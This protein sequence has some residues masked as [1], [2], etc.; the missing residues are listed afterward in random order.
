M[1][2]ALVGSGGKTTLLKKLAAQYL[3]E[4]KTVFVTTTTHMFI[5]ENTLLTE[6]AEEIIRTLQTT[7]YAM[8]GKTDGEKIIALSKETFDTVCAHADVVLVEADGS[9]QMPLKYPNDRE[10][11]IPEHTDEIIIVCGLQA[12]GRPAKEVC[13]RLALVREVLGIH[14]ETIITPVHIQKLLQEGY[15]S[16]LRNTYPDVKLTIAP[17]HNHSLY[18]R[19]IA[20]M[21]KNECDVSII[22]KE[23]FCP[24]PTLFI[25]G[26]GHVAKETA[27]LAKYLDFRVT[28]IDDR[29]ELANTKN[30]PTA[31]RIICDSYD[32][33]ADYLEPDSCYVVVTPNHKADLQCVSIILPTSYRYLGMIGSKNKVAATFENLRAAGFS[34]EQIASIF[35]PIGLSIG[36]VTPAEI[37]FSILAQIIQEKNKTHSASADRELLECKESG[38]L[39]IITEKH[40]STPRGA[41]SMMFVGHNKIL[42]SIGGGEP[43]RLVIN[44]ARETSA[45]T[46]RE[47]RLNNQL[48]KG[49]DMVCGGTITV[50]F[51][52]ME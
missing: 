40:G 13:H 12:L 32:N 2:K 49:L 43:E 41:G 11:V 45:V 6:D 3:A 48:H 20:A 25:C 18:Q 42:G 51:I 4:G 1:I 29:E 36:A 50:L 37:A 8:A 17:S 9:K 23:W 39:C 27:A 10:P 47:Y 35:A 19:T 21:L 28:I 34:E 38:V 5:E 44:C 7:G 24:Q 16:P 14:D 22:Q 15:L 31:D 26:G 30:F 46:V 52:P 33:L